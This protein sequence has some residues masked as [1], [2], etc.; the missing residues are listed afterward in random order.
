M[1]LFKTLRGRGANARSTEALTG[2]LCKN[3]EVTTKFS[4]SM[5]DGLQ[6]ETT[7]FAELSFCFCAA[8]QKDGAWPDCF[9][10]CFPDV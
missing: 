7:M 9:Q 8:A 2:C 5:G 6:A 4:Y 1:A 3:M 10:G